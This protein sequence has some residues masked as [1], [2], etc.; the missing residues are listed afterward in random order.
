MADDAKRA[1]G[2]GVVSVVGVAEDGRPR[3]WWASPRTFSAGSTPW[4]WSVGH[5]RRSVARAAVAGPISRRRAAPTAPGPKRRTP[6]SKRPSPTP[7]AGGPHS[8]RRQPRPWCGS[9][10]GGGGLSRVA[11]SAARGVA[12][13]DGNRA[14]SGRFRV[15]FRLPLGTGPHLESEVARLRRI[16][17]SRSPRNAPTPWL[18]IE[19]KAES[20]GEGLGKPFRKDFT[21]E[22]TPVLFIPLATAFRGGGPAPRM[23]SVG[24]V[25]GRAA[26]TPPN[27]RRAAECWC[28][29]GAAQQPPVSHPAAVP[30]HGP[31]DGSGP[32]RLDR[33][34]P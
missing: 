21:G 26:L 13:S 14:E 29:R 28:A 7:E 31:D 34:N 5:P 1:V 2:S 12:C 20:K 18:Q 23:S 27:G 25:F 16:G 32:G 30:D 24:A 9:P 15:R 22:I 33:R 11:W 19:S 8:P 4:R 10:P 6:P 17:V 3:L